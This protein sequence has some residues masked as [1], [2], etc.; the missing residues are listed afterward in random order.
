MLGL[1]KVGGRRFRFAVGALVASLLAVVW[2]AVAALGT[3]H[4]FWDWGFGL[5]KMYFAWGLYVVGAAGVFAVLG[6]IASL[7]R[8]PRL[9]GTIVSL[10]ALLVVGLLAGRLYG[11]KLQA[12]V[13][14][15]IHDVQT[16]F[17]RPVVFSD[18]L[19]NARVAGGA[20][21]DVL[22]DPVVREGVGGINPAWEKFSG[23]S[24]AEAQAL[25]VASGNYAE[26]APLVFDARADEVFD[27]TLALVE[28]RGWD[29]VT[30]N[31][32][33]GRIEATETSM[34]FGFKDDV[35]I[36]IRDV[37]DR[38][39]VDMR[40]VSRVGLSDLGAN[41]RRIAV[42]LQDLNATQ[43]VSSGF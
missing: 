35:A 12:D 28:A 39:R 31:K 34:W 30:S 25:A 4:G 16:D 13:V 29:V 40:S 21:N 6:L 5:R 15:P 14:P 9:N 37:D 18:T 43:G 41:Q 17:D 19:L 27:A 23:L 36:Y 26:I 11:L 7:I 8:Y 42:F 38:T 10:A 24:N 32:A 3:K 2:F 33:E 20:E 1:F 22:L